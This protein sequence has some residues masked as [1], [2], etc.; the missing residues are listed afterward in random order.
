MAEVK[1][2]DQI[3]VALACPPGR[4]DVMF[5][6]AEVK[7]F[8][9]RVTAKGV[10]VFLYQ[11]RSGAKVCRLRLGVWP[12]LT[13]PKARKLA[14]THRG[15]VHVGGDPVGEKR[16]R[17]AAAIAADA[18]R[19]VEEADAALT[20]PRL[21]ELWQDKG[22]G[23]RRPRYV[24][25]AGKRLSTYFPAWKDRPASTITRREAVAALDGVEAQ[26]G[27]ISARRSMAYA[28][29]CYG[30][31]L[32]RHMLELNPFQGIAA[33]GKENPRDRVLSAEEVGAVW[34][35]SD[36]LGPFQRPFLRLLLLTLQR[37][38]EVAGMRWS[39]IS[40]DGLTWTVPAARAK[41]GRAHL[42]HLAPTARE[43]LEAIPRMGES[44]LVFP[45]R[46]D[47]PISSFSNI[48]RA[49]DVAIRTERAGQ[50]LKHIEL[51]DWRFHDFR[52]TGVTSLAGLGFAPHVCDRM[53]NHVTGAI[54]GV[55]AVYQRAE[56]LA[57]R[58]AA[59]EAWAVHV[60]GKG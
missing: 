52:R 47:R 32:K 2:T 50:G 4:K 28:R 3:V 57:E 60:G 37:R 9:V 36:Q 43:L 30:W 18:A 12:G 17:K 5:F 54:Q 44:D 46:G 23:H 48:K 39:E 13:A 16:E 26:R 33:P 35:A 25:D 19:K 45:G 42:V 51:P 1:L 11:Y 31:A 55:A 7:G 10:R 49:L 56:F 34:R 21:V 22:I 8:G 58:K 20:F 15:A 24:Q 53:L 6:D 40:A 41:N 14:E 27:T 59:L 38:E 29:A